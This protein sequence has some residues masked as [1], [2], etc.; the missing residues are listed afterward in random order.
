MSRSTSARSPRPFLT[1]VVFLYGLAVLL[2]LLALVGEAG[3]ALADD[4]PAVDEFDQPRD[5]TA[6]ELYGQCLTNAVTSFDQCVEGAGF[7]QEVGC[8]IAWSID[9]YACA[10]MLPVN[11]AVQLMP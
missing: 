4:C 9:Y 8:N 2:A 11:L 7:W 10:A 5:C 1:R 3:P 6:M